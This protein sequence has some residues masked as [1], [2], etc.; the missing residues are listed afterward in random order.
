M[1]EGDSLPHSCTRNP[2]PAYEIAPRCKDVIFICQRRNYCYSHNPGYRARMVR[3]CPV[4]GPTCS[5]VLGPG[6]LDTRNARLTTTHTTHTCSRATS[7][8][9]SFSV[10]TTTK[11][12]CWFSC[13]HVRDIVPSAW[14]LAVALAEYPKYTSTRQSKEHRKRDS[15]LDN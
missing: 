7:F 13:M 6:V 12:L 3:R 8:S 15:Y 5:N 11:P 9:F 14:F 2:F 10:D 1:N 4:G